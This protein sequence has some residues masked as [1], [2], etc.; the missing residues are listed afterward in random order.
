MPRNPGETPEHRKKPRSETIQSNRGKSSL[1]MFEARKDLHDLL[2]VNSD[3]VFASRIAYTQAAPDI[4]D[5]LRLH[6]S[7]DSWTNL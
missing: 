2:P 1:E 4:D 7:L 6:V 5:T 3:V